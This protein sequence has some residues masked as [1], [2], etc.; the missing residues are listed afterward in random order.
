M[1]TTLAK[2]RTVVLTKALLAKLVAL[3]LAG[4]LALEL[5]H[6]A[7][8]E[9]L[10]ERLGIGRVL[11]GRFTLDGELAVRVDLLVVHFAHSA[12]RRVVFVEGHEAEAAR[13]AF[14]VRHHLCGKDLAVRQKERLQRRVVQEIPE[15][16]HE[17]VLEAS[18][19]LIRTVLPLLKFAHEP[20]IQYIQLKP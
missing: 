11:L 16:L 13:L 6:R 14:I 5:L 18:C 15:V 4:L 12:V 2:F 1:N 19:C 17:A 9:D 10:L 7:S 8:H 20:I 3:Q